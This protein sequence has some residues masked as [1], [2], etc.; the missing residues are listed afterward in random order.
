MG[1]GILPVAIKNNTVYFLFGKEN[2]LDDTQGWADF[3][4]G[5]EESESYFDTALREGGEEI[6][7]FLGFGEQLRK[8]VK[9]N[10]IIKVNL[11]TYH[12]FI[13]KMDY[14]EN[15]PFYYKNNYEFFSRYL[16]HV[17]HKRDNGL[18]EKAKIKWFSFQELKEKKG[19]FRPFYQKIVDL[20]LKKEKI[21]TEKMKKNKKTRYFK[22][23][24][25][26]KKKTKKNMKN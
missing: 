18:L 3:G 15:L 11:P 20:I 16:P 13:F 21:I 22:T 2:E 8:R 1:G 12:T 17:K 9:K 6:N 24:N 5:K 26:D 7:G 10:H 23:N 19:E 14:D 25:N 4:G